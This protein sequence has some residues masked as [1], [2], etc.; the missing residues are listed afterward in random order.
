MKIFKSIDY[1]SRDFK[2][3][4]KGEESYKTVL[5]GISSILLFMVTVV[6]TWYFGQDIY[7]KNNPRYLSKTSYKNYTPVIALN[8]SS[9]LYAL[10]N[11]KTDKGYFFEE[12]VYQDF[13]TFNNLIVSSSHTSVIFNNSIIEAHFIMNKKNQLHNRDYIKIPDIIAQV[14]GILSLFLPFV[15]YFLR[16][17]ID[18]EY[19]IYLYY[20]LFQIQRMNEDSIDN[21]NS[22]NKQIELKFNIEANSPIIESNIISKSEFKTLKVEIV[23]KDLIRNYNSNQSNLHNTSNH[24]L[25]NNK[26]R[27]L[28][29]TKKEIVLNKDIDK[30]I[31]A[32]NQ[33]AVNLKISKS[34][35]LTFLCSCGASKIDKNGLYKFINK[36]ESELSIKCDFVEISKSLDQFRLLKKLLNEGQCLLLNNRELKQFLIKPIEIILRK[37]VM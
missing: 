7:L 3:N 5:G 33:K 27:D 14:G 21:I 18:N 20:S 16:I 19:T 2:L 30:A 34:N 17:F 23:N 1:F 24:V 22:S 26:L 9:F 25:I 10:T 12:V 15:E 37:T 8:S 35:R 11:L 13:L 31:I 4:F 29:F 36:L 6:L 32:K 28:K